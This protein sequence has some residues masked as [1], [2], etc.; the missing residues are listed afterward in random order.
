MDA[1]RHDRAEG[2]LTAARHPQLR[3]AHGW[4]QAQTAA[5][6]LSSAPTISHWNERLDEDGPDALV[7]VPV[8]VSGARLN[9]IGPIQGRLTDWAALARCRGAFANLCAYWRNG[10]PFLGGGTT[11]EAPREHPLV[12]GITWLLR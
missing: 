10:A 1:P 12:S 5:R 9:L 3:A 7:Q 8:P 6:F 4:S 2:L 11:H